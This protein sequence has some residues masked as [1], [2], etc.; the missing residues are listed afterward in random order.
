MAKKLKWFG[1]ALLAFVA[2]GLAA[3]YAKLRASSQI[4][5]DGAMKLAGLSAPVTVL[6]DELGTPY[7]FAA[8]TPDL[9]KAQGF[10]TAQHRLMQMELLRASWRGELAATFGPDALPSDIRMR[11]IGLRRNGDLHATK[12]DA[13]SRVF[14]QNYVDG[15]NAY[16]TT[17]VADHPIELKLAGITPR[18]WDVADLTTLVQYGHYTHATNFK[19]EVVAQ[20][21]IDK[22]GAVRA[23]EISPLLINPDW[24][25]A[26][27]APVAA[28]ATPQN[29]TAQL[30]LKWR[31]LLA[32]PETLNPQGLGS[33]N[34]AVGPSR[35][36]SG[37]A[38][39]SND[40][41][42]DNRMLP[43]TWHPV[44]L[45][46]PEIQAVGA[47]FPGM[48]GILVG[49]TKHVA[50]GVTNAYGDEVGVV[51]GVLDLKVEDPGKQISLDCSA[52]NIRAPK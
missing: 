30:G 15:V 5:V 29:Q 23:Q 12:L 52:A 26:P 14:F 43:G 22:L 51:H 3:G 17:Q 25:T 27:L 21:L 20:E 36:A 44:G 50:F 31:E 18:V 37:K 34:W 16:I 8:N 45:F 28:N 6:R 1:L 9:I 7:I 40:P 33:N 35:T 11:V 19:T 4:Q 38:I 24:K 2:I 46:S 48:P 47:A 10:V 42:L 13:S 49:R 39:V 41:H 32:G